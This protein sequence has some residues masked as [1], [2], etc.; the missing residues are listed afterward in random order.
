MAD[1]KET[2][3]LRNIGRRNIEIGGMEFK[4]NKTVD[5]PLEQ[6]ER[7]LKLFPDEVEDLHSAVE[8]FQSGQADAFVQP[9]AD[10]TDSGAGAPDGTKIPPEPMTLGEAIL[11]LDHKNDAHWTK[12]GYPDLN[13]VRELTGKEISAKERDAAAGAYNRDAAKAAAEAKPAE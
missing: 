5:F 13:A 3:R 8:K 11:A 6:A 12:G 2:K 10:V 1:T 7:L 9:A 4:P